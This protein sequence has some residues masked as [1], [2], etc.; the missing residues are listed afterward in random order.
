M[1]NRVEQHY[2]DVTAVKTETVFRKYCSLNNTTIVVRM[3][4]HG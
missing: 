4:R 2:D 1:S 3:L